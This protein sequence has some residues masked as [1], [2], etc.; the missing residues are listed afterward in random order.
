MK[1]RHR[2]TKNYLFPNKMSSFVGKIVA[3]FAKLYAVQSTWNIFWQ[4]HWNCNY[5]YK[6]QFCLVWLCLKFNILK[7][8]SSLSYCENRYLFGNILWLKNVLFLWLQANTNCIQQDFEICTIFLYCISILFQFDNIINSL[9][10]NIAVCLFMSFSSTFY[11]WQWEKTDKSVIKKFLFT[12]MYSS[13]LNERKKK[14]YELL[15]KKVEQY[16]NDFESNFFTK[17]L[18]E[19]GDRNNIIIEML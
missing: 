2:I 1:S 14:N 6:S 17:A 10:C 11:M 5:F 16:K 9:S 7:I 4:T 18:F 3:K 8:T 15:P 19:F 13:F 12:C